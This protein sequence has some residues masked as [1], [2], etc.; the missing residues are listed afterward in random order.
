MPNTVQ[1]GMWD[2]TTNENNYPFPNFNGV[3][4]DE[5]TNEN[6]YPFPNFNDYT[7]EVWE[8]I[9]IFIPQLIMDV[10]TYPCWE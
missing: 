4:W 1:C 7:V 2:E 8:W 6:T 9:I 10:I 3:M 5:T